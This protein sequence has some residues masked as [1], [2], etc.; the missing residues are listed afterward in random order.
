MA[1]G[2][3][4]K[5]LLIGMIAGGVIGALTALLAAPKSGKELRND[6]TEQVH[7]VSEKTQ[8]A[9]HAVGDKTTK[10]IGKVQETA[11]DV[12]ENV[13]SW[14]DASHD[15]DPTEEGH[16]SDFDLADGLPVTRELQMSLK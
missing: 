5:D 6:I 9:V 11:K 8:Q 1:D 15:E 10:W 16:T 14:K 13:R 2:K 12:I 3:R 7:T 4:S